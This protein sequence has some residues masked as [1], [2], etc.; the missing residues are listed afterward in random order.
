[1][2]IYMGMIHS[3]PWASQNKAIHGQNGTFCS[4]HPY[5]EPLWGHAIACPKS[6]LMILS[7]IFALP[8]PA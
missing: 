6:F 4:P 1:M 5:D 7:L 3:R 2:S 8:S